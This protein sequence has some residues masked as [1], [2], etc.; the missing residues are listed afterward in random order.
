MSSFLIDCFDDVGAFR[1]GVVM[2]QSTWCSSGVV[3]VHA[4]F[5]QMDGNSVSELGNVDFVPPGTHGGNSCANEFIN[6]F[7]GRK[8]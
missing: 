4:K 3:E 1:L 5:V 2:A 7:Q 8:K 6:G